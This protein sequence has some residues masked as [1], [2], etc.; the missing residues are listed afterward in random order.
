MTQ[1]DN[2]PAD[3]ATVAAQDSGAGT[4]P[5]AD[6]QPKPKKDDGFFASMAWLILAVVVLRSFIISPFSIPSESM[7]PRLLVGDY[8]FASKWSYGFSKYSL[9]FSVPLIPGRILAHQP[10]RGDIVIFKAPPSNDVD[11]VKRVIGLPG[12]Q[13]QMKGGQL[14]INGK[15]VPKVKTDDF[16]VPESPNTHCYSPEFE[17]VDDK[18]LP[19]CRY[20]Q[21]RETLPEG[22]SYNVLDLGQ[23]PRDDTA[24]YVVPEGALFLMGDN[25][26]NSLDSR[27][28]TDEG[29]ISFVPQ[30]NLVGKASVMMFSTDGSASWIKPW[31]WFTAARWS[32]IGGMF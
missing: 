1:P 24:V 22:K 14:F 15:S 9:P 10:A 20:P 5:A 28:S 25:R 27:Y 7:L 18:G 16:V 2:Q 29:G 4:L 11:W 13:I 32:R 21:F 8:L 12:D 19:V 23:I 31:T 30:G 17:S 26:D 3:P 6:G